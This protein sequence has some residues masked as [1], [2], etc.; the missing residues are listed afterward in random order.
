MRAAVVLLLLVVAEA[1]SE[2]SDALA[3]E[4]LAAGCNAC[5]GPDG[6]GSPPVPAL[7]GRD[8][9]HVLLEGWREE[10][11]A[12]GRAH[13]MIRFARALDG[14][15]TAALAAHYAADDAP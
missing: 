6:Q 9:L 5:H 13:I 12:K 14:A 15:D 1:G 10:P 2:Q 8:D 3:T 11:E 7:R 4:L